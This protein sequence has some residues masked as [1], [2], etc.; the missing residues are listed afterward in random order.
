MK[1]RGRLNRRAQRPRSFASE[2]FVLA[3][4]NAGLLNGFVL[5]TVCLA[6]LLALGLT[7]A[8]AQQN[9]TWTGATSS[10]WNT[11]TNWLSVPTNSV[12]TGTA[13][14]NSIGIA[15][16]DITFSADSTIQT[17]IFNAPGYNFTV[18][19]IS[20]LEVTG[21]GVEAPSSSNFPTIVAANS[22]DLH[23]INSSTAVLLKLPPQTQVT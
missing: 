21:G 17:L 6:A 2:R 3:F 15:T 23:F 18:D 12:P 19:T 1:R 5:P 13:T 14:F 8:L 11:G 16:P 4:L 22:S 7:P 20:I 9:A 10:D